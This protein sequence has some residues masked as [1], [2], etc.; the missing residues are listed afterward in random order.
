MVSD[1]FCEV[2]FF[3][4]FETEVPKRVFVSDSLFAKIGCF[5]AFLT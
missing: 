1:H 4:R 2:V 5:G 3:V